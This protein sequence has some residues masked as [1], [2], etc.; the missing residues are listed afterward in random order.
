MT[1]RGTTEAEAEDKAKESSEVLYDA[2]PD[3]DHEIVTL[4]SGIK[5]SK[6][7]GWFCY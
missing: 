5:C 2:D 6:C 1:V 3:C 4:W 7:P